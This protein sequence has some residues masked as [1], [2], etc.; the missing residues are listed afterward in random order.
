MNYPTTLYG[1]GN[2]SFGLGNLSNNNTLYNQG[3]IA[4]YSLGSS[5]PSY[6]APSYSGVNSTALSGLGTSTPNMTANAITQQVANG[7]S[8]TADTPTDD[9]TGE[10]WFSQLGGFKGLSNLAQ[11]LGS[12]GQIYSAIKG[13][14][15]AQDQFD[16]NKQA[17]NTNLANTTK[18]YNTALEGKTKARYVM[19][20][21]SS[22]AA[23]EYIAKHSL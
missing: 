4:Q 20:N 2:L 13:V 5:T 7:D 22:E 21:K 8:A 1:N 18:S 14:Q 15:L 9:V 17:Y 23:D 16:F 3:N 12:L 10:G 19:E 6:T 11:G